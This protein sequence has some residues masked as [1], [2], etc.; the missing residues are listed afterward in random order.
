MAWRWTA[1]VV[2]LGICIFDFI[3]VPIW[4]GFMRPD[5]HTFLE[6]VRMIDDTMVKLELMKK[7]TDHH[8]PYT[9]MGGG[10]LH[11]AFG[12]L[13]TGSVFGQNTKD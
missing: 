6:E 11:L 9:L 1:L 13:L 5:Y 8:N 2:Y 7:L 10:L 12:A 4:Y 3:I